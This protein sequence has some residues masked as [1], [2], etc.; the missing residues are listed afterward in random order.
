MRVA[1]ELGLDKDPEF[2]THY[3]LAELT[4]W[5]GFTHL[6]RAENNSAQAV[7]GQEEE[8]ATRLD[9]AADM[10]RARLQ[11]WSQSYIISISAASQDPLKAQRLAST[12]AN[13][14]L[15]SQREARQEALQ[16][17]ATWLRGRVD[18]LHSQVLQTEASIEKLR[19]E[20]GLRDSG[21]YNLSEPQMRE[22]NTQLMTVRADVEKKRA[23]LEQ[24]RRVLAAN[25]G[26]Q[27]TISMP[28]DIQSIPELAASA[29]LTAL[30]QKQVE[31]NW[32]TT[33]LQNKLGGHHVQVIN[34][35]AQLAGV[36][37]QIKAETQHVL[38]NMESA[39]NIAVRQE[40]ALEANLKS[41]AAAA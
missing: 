11:V 24:A 21:R 29:E 23:D 38:A 20:S 8:K 31:L 10:L 40:Q 1:R 14:Y 28:S 18:D 32:R 41:T 5:L 4:A 22:L 2:Q 33:E 16:R 25:Q 26:A 17:V 12:V 6:G 19:A 27:S 3:R 37:Q 35:Q 9:E 34:I 36:N 13:D 30:R 39:Y 15:A 7:G